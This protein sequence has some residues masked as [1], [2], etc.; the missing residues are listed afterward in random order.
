ML[1]VEY[2]LNVKCYLLSPRIMIRKKKSLVNNKHEQHFLGL[3]Y[4]V[5]QDCSIISDADILNHA[6][7]Q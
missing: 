6:F 7:L 5:T 3:L 2:H 1:N 4:N